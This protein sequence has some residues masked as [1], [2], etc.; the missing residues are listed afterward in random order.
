MPRVLILGGA[1]FYGRWLVTYLVENYKTGNVRVLDKTT[2]EC[3]LLSNRCRRA[4]AEVEFQQCNLTLIVDQ[5]F[6][7]SDGE[8]W[9]VVYNLAC[10]RRPEVSEHAYEENICTLTSVCANAAAKYGAKLFVQVSSASVYSDYHVHSRE[11]DEIDESLISSLNASAKYF[12]RADQTLLN[13]KNLNVIIM[14]PSTVYGPGDPHFI[15]QMMMVGRVHRESHTAVYSY[16]SP[17][18]CL[19]TVH[20]YDLARALWHVFLWYCDSGRQ[21]HE[22]FNVTDLNDSTNGS[23][24]SVIS[25][26]FG[27]TVKF[28]WWFVS[29]IL[30]SSVTANRAISEANSKV[31]P[32]WSRLL[33]QAGIQD[34]PLTPYFNRF[35]LLPPSVQVDGTKLYA[36]TGFEYLVPRVTIPALKDMIREWQELRCWPLP[37]TTIVDHSDEY[38]KGKGNNGNEDRYM[39]E[40]IKSTIRRPNRRHKAP[41]SHG[42]SKSAIDPSDRAIP[43]HSNMSDLR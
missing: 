39:D 29:K 26:L 11:E 31:V 35:H 21:G 10:E 12:Y 43:L 18:R 15:A 24:W 41:I 2:P 22:I 3:S 1:G 27:V 34:S 6:Q 32:A 20:V 38:S 5:G 13:M 14:R 4:F 7:R 40:I 42:S 8:P 25:R 30:T 16:L 37:D 17:D 19:N 28:H 33:R 36:L 23:L 9:D